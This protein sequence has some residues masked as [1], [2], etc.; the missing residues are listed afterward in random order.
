MDVVE[1]KTIVF[2]YENKAI[3]TK[4]ED[5]EYEEALLYLFNETKEAKY[6]YYLG[7][8][9]YEQR[10]FDL[11]LKYYSLARDLGYTCVNLCL[12]YVFYYGRTGERDYKSAFEAF[13]TIIEARLGDHFELGEVHSLM[14]VEASIKLAD[15]YKN[16][17]YVSKNYDEYK[18]IINNLYKDIDFKKEHNVFNPYVEIALR[19]ARILEEEGKID[20]ALELYYICKE[21]LAIRLSCNLF[22]GDINQM[23]WT[24]ND[25]YRL[26]EFDKVSFDL[27]DLFY[28]LKDEHIIQFLFNNKTYIIESK[29]V[30][31]EMSYRFED[32]WYRSF[33]ELLAKTT[34]KDESLPLLDHY[35]RLSNWMILK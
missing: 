14:K 3:R 6:V 15:M 1:A 30:N 11:A 19:K 17:Y 10:V 8:H 27:Y 34:I 32:K 7:S 28:L 31:E 13:K 9:Y 26:T 24:I 18:N 33:N 4:E 20:E 16:G 35:S 23:S 25:I 5:F 12:G 21:E 22:F 2:N 29:K